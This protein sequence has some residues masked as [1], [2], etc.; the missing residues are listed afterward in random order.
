MNKFGA[1]V[2]EIEQ[3]LQGNMIELRHSRHT[4]FYVN[5]LYPHA[6]DA[7]LIA[8]R[9]HDIGKTGSRKYPRNETDRG[10]FIKKD[11]AAVAGIMEGNG[12]EKGVAERVRWLIENNEKYGPD[13]GP[14]LQ[15]LQC[16]DLFDAAVFKVPIRHLEGA[17]VVQ[18]VL[19]ERIKGINMVMFSSLEPF[20]K[21]PYR[22]Q[23]E[24]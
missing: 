19:F 11:A 5:E 1:V 21:N 8:A 9:G 17:E 4:A 2:L 16:A 24:Q 23:D 3:R 15:A 20:I 6:D 22:C 7:L 18:D 10:V 14:G 13:G 12:Y